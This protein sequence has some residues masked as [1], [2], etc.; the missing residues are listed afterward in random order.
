VKV[1]I[2]T[3]STPFVH[4]GAS[5]FVDW[6][7][8]ALQE[9][10]H[11]VEV[12][13]I[14]VLGE[15]DELPLQML[16]LRMWDFTGHGDR[17]ITVRTPSHLVRHHHKVAWFI[18]HHRPAYDLWNTHRDV[19]DDSDGHEFR[20]M[21]FSADE[22]AL[23]ECKAVFTNSQTVTDRLKRFN[24]VDSEVLYP[25][26]GRNAHVPSG[27]RGN[28]IVGISRVVPH[29]RQ[30]LAVQAMAYTNSGVRLHI[31]GLDSDGGAYAETIGH[32]I[33]RLGLRDRVTFEHAAISDDRK[34]QL[35]SSA[36]AV[37]HAPV[38]EDS[39]GYSGLEAASARR[40]LVTTTDSGGVLELIRDGHNGLVVTPDPESMGA[41][42][43]RLYEDREL[44]A[45]LGEAQGERMA[46]LG[47][48][49]DHTISRLL[50]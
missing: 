15:P 33:D 13:P 47:I 41:A 21:L 27:P 11:E 12:Y 36:L 43:D 26:L 40:A 30:L 24:G 4:G 39:Y 38:D 8:Q 5:V 29:K 25:P 20:R 50:A 19:P 23:A 7:E 37:V 22:A 42:F 10:G 48:D 6:L 9:R 32:E 46:T 31:A 28:T 49:W 2:V 45:H 35:L 17:L 14:P 44:A 16:G 34:K 18:H 3:S 1:V